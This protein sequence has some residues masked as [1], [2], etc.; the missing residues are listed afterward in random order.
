MNN[1][2]LM[3]L[4]LAATAAVSLVVVLIHDRVVQEG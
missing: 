4:G 3:L 2:L 1:G